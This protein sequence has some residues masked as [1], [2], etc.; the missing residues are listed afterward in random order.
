MVSPAPLSGLL[1]ASGADARDI[2]QA[3]DAEEPS[4]H[5]QRKTKRRRMP[6]DSDLDSEGDSGLGESGGRAHEGLQMDA[7]A[8][9]LGPAG[10]GG[11]LA[12]MPC[13]QGIAFER[14][15]K[16]HTF[17]LDC[18]KQVCCS[19]SASMHLQ[20]TRTRVCELEAH[21]RV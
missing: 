10:S 8:I 14:S 16:K 12:V 6:L 5:W 18:I 21:A 1:C 17:C 3:D 15:R 2:L 19:A 4:P 20:M 9:C 7:C 11:G 13:P